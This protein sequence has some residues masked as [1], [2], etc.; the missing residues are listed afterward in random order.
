MACSNS[1]TIVVTRH[2][3]TLQELNKENGVAWLGLPANEDILRGK[4]A[5]K[6]FQVYGSAV[7][8]GPP[9]PDQ[10]LYITIYNKK[11]RNPS[12]ALA[13]VERRVGASEVELGSC[14][15]CFEEMS[16][17]KLLMACGRPGCHQKVDDDCLREWVRT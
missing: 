5:F 9:S 16:K 14:A 8:G 13:Q 12:D 11:I 7:F 6:L 15:L 2:I 4:S 17:P 3:T 1:E 10:S